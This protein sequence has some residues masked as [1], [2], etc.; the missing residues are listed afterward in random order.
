MVRTAPTATPLLPLAQDRAQAHTKPAIQRPERG[1]VTMLE[2][3]EPSHQ[4]LV[5]RL[6]DDF[7]AAAISRPCLTQKGVFRFDHALAAR[8]PVSSLKVIADKVESP[9]LRGVEDSRLF[10]IQ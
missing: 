1:R 6:D 3:H 10:R 9:S 7:K 5:H 4:R 8:P 2:I